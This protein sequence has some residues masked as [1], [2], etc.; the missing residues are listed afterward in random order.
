MSL[1]SE[2]LSVYIQLRNKYG[3]TSIVQVSTDFKIQTVTQ[4][5]LLG[6][7]V[8]IEPS[9]YTPITSS[10]LQGNIFTLLSEDIL[11]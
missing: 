5:K 10:V 1:V 3:G 2:K 4:F 6:G 7:S 11:N 8:K 9:I